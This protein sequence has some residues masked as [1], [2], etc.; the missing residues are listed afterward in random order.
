MKTKETQAAKLKKS[1]ALEPNLRKAGGFGGKRF[2]GEEW[3]HFNLT[4]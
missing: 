4:G 3:T 1:Q 2:S